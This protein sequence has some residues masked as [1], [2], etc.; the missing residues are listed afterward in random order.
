LYDHQN[1]PNETK[2][3]AADFPEVVA[4][5]L[6]ILEKANTGLYDKTGGD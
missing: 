2:N 1:D 6:P 5:L 3:I 4:E